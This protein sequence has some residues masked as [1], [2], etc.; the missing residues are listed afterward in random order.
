MVMAHPSFGHYEVLGPIGA[1]GM[2]EV[3]VARDPNLGRKVAI[4][5]LPLRLTTER[6]T[7]TRFT[8][9]ARSASALNHPNIVTIYEVGAAEG[10]PYIVM[11]Y[12]DGQDLR[13]LIQT[14]PTPVRKAL[15]LAC[16]IAD[17]LAAAHDR[18]IVHRDLKPENIMVTRDGGFVKILDFGLAKIITPSPESGEDTLQLEMPGTNPGTILGTVGYMSPEQATGRRLDFRS[19]QFAFGAILY[20]LV[21]GKPAF[22]GET[23]I[24]TL[25]AIL[26]HDPA[27]LA[28]ANVR[29]PVQLADIVR[30]LLS[31]SADERYSSSRDLAREI[32]MLRDRVIAE[33]S[34]FH[35]PV[36]PR[37]KPIVAIVAAL[38]LAI[39]IVGVVFIARKRTGA[40]DPPPSAAVAAPKKYLAVMGFKAG[41]PTG[42]L[43]AEGFTETLT[44]RLSRYSS[45]QVIRP[46]SGAEPETNDPRQYA[47]NLGANLVLSG[48]MQREG[49]RIRVTYTVVEA[50]SGRRWDELVD[51]TASDLF[52]VQDEVADSVARNL[53]LGTS[54]I[55]VQLDPAVSQRKYLEAVGHLRRYDDAESLESAISILKQLGPSPTVQ[56]AL[57]RAYLLKFQDTRDAQA[58]L[59]AS[60]AAARALESDPQSLDVNVTLGHL[61]RQT[62]RHS[63]AIDAFLRV[64]SQ[65]P[66]NA[67]AVLGLAQTYGASG[68]V[69][70]AEES[71]RRAIALQP[72]FWGAYNQ[73]GVFY[74][75]QSRYRDAIPLFQKVTQL[76]PDNEF[77]YNNLAAMHQLL[78]RYDEAVRVTQQS[79]QRKPTAY[80]Y[81]NLGLRYYYTGR[82]AD[83]A[84]ATEKAVAL[85]PVNAMYWRNLGDAYRWMPGQAAKARSA[86]SRAAEL[87]EDAI[88]VNPK[89]ARAHRT[90]AVA[91][92][93]LGENQAA[94]SAILRALEVEP[95]RWSNVYEA[96][97]IANIAG[98]EAE[99]VARLE[100]AIRLGASVEDIRRDPEFANLKKTGRLEAIISGVRSTPE[101]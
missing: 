85:A 90:R 4:K 5:M 76:V 54:S 18:G 78:G 100:Q 44:A 88:R 40:A 42:Q 55:R 63:E 6:D 80:A 29:V 9:E 65:Q 49:E 97:V 51:G 98:D 21:T 8:Q 86:Y 74:Y 52:S 48:V 46:V 38:A 7:L 20:E 66:N 25:S 73:L 68:D 12:I 3:F 2:G 87:C 59:A 84:V 26:H 24:D 95:T 70:R 93:K 45:V 23:A 92:A 101:P 60:E 71:Y 89:D 33:E 16:Q 94:R 15:D 10:V 39:F 31:K 91:L 14:G 75:E 61:R 28:K 47:R 62:G 83:A 82:F 11:E 64:L 99:A 58:A 41:D 36:E 30:R 34:G 32:R 1:G 72:N 37:T 17:G 77:G 22:D 53:E 57:A 50:S 13:T 43:V 56:A 27:S 96:G 35:Q 67:E 19:D 81:T 79:I 69:K